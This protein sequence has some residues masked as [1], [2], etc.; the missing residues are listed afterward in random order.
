MS[1]ERHIVIALNPRTGTHRI[2]GVLK[3]PTEDT[4]RFTVP[5]EAIAGVAQY[6]KPEP[7]EYVMALS[8]KFAETAPSLPP[9]TLRSVK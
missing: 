1:Q 5:P 2:A 3:L 6:L 8:V 9:A 7:H 4:P